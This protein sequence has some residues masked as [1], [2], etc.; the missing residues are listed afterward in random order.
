MST[1]LKEKAVKMTNMKSCLVLGVATAFA[2]LSGLTFAQD[3]L[4]D[5]LKDLEGTAAKP[6][7]KA[8]APA[9]EEPAKAEEPAPRTVAVSATGAGA[10][11]GEQV[12]ESAV[13]APV[14]V[15]GDGTAEAEPPVVSA[16]K[17]DEVMTLLDQLATENKVQP[18]SAQNGDAAVQ[19]QAEK[20]A[21]DAQA[22][23]P[24]VAAPRVADADQPSA[25]TAPRAAEP[26]GEAAAGREDAAGTVETPAQ[27]V[28]AS[29]PVSPDAELLA[30]I[31]T[32]EK[33]RREALD[34]QAKREIS[35]ARR[36]MADEEYDEAVRHY[37]LALKL[38]NDRPSSKGLRRECDQGMAEGLYRA[39][40]QED[41]LGRRDRAVK[42]MEKAIDMRHPKA[43]RVLEKWNASDDP[44]EER[45]GLADI[46]HRV[47]D[48]DYKTSREQIRRHLRRSRQYLAVRDIKKALEECEVVLVNDPYNQDAI[49]IREAIQKKR[50]VILA[51]ERVAARDGMIADVDEAWRP[52][53]A[54]NAAQLKD[55]TAETVK[56]Q[57]GEDPERT[58]EQDIERR[59]KEMRL[60]TI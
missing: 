13:A 45:A 59:M 57:T 50:K 58:M 12:A 40:L 3:D 27:P 31:R 32:T 54:V 47:N 52:V 56:Q 18:A 23:E 4:D 35:E 51:Q 16:K 42:L 10:Q 20:A 60:P 2:I 24:A 34:V 14:A 30:N 46:K 37:G 36:S 44:A 21:A 9:A 41:E 15:D 25:V 49:R 26:S 11:A 33:L 48:E 53:Y 39:A 7:A 29:Q 8:E 38:L 22:G 5:L 55:A 6:A 28:V 17:V 1:K 19:A 43:R